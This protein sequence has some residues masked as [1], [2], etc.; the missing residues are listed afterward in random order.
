MTPSATSREARS[1][2]KRVDVPPNWKKQP[3]TPTQLD[4]RSLVLKA[5]P[6]S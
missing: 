1:A 2:V 6:E 4:H 3:R 5:L